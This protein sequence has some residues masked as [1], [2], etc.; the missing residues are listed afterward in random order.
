VRRRSIGGGVRRW[1]QD[2][3]PFPV[4]VVTAEAVVDCIEDHF[5]EAV[6]L[7]GYLEEERHKANA[8]FIRKGR[9]QERQ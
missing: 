2:G 9:H 5:A 7:P 6:G 8:L 3:E 4:A 1:I